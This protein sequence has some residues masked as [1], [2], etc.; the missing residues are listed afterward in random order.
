MKRITGIIL[1]LA[2]FFSMIGCTTSGSDING[3]S[4]VNLC[5]KYMAL[6]G[7]SNDSG[8][9]YLD[10]DLPELSPFSVIDASRALMT[11]DGFLYVGANWCPYCR[12][13]MP[14]L[15]DVLIQNGISIN[16]TELDEIKS[17]WS[18]DENNSPVCTREGTDEYY[19]LLD[20]LSGLLRDYTLKD[21]EGIVHQ[22]G[23]KRI[24]MPCIFRIK[25]GNP[26]E[27]W[28]LQSVEGY[29]AGSDSY[30]QWSEYQ[31]G[32]VRMSLSKFILSD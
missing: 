22:T 21:S 29:E 11:Q 32:L 17:L 9:Q 13:L 28:S 3:L 27:M 30:E 5:E 8:K 2:I 10:I 16:A 12:N 31:S 7:L 26:V 25:D 23:E 20:R 18:L 1:F 19:R 4:D 6:N 15:V 14:V 24:Y